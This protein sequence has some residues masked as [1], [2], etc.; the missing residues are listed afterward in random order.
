[1]RLGTYL[2]YKRKENVMG[3]VK[4]NRDIP[5]LADFFEISRS[6]LQSEEEIVEEFIIELN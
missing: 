1:M 6:L 4:F 5:V 3:L 2:S